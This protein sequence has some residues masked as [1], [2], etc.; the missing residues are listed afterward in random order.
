M[1]GRADLHLHT[2]QSDGALRADHLLLKVKDAGLSVVSITDHD[3]ISAVDEAIQIGSQLGVDVIPGVEL[4]ASYNNL[5]IHIL[6]Y[7]FDRSNKTLLDALAVF[8]E[9]RKRRVERIVD[10]LNKLNIPIKI[11]SVLANATGE[12]IGRP[13]VASAMVSEGHAASYLQAF[14]KYLGD[15]K[16]AYEK[17]D[18]FSPEETIELIAQAGGLSF[19][20]HPGLS[21]S[22]GFVVRLIEAGLDGIE[23][24]HPSHSTELV[25][26]YRDIVHQYYLLECGGSDFHGGIKNDEQT[27]GNV[28]IPISAVDAMRRR[29]YP[30]P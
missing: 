26:Y 2:S 22:D 11:E 4:S 5:E 23:V 21:V 15:G 28:T 8:Q 27:L 10:K 3:S 25:R 12:S 6:G 9:K 17:K 29:L 13:H 30:A 24:V 14:N 16:P 19:L 18:G 1:D 20:A 7:F